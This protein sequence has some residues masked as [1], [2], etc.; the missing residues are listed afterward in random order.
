MFFVTWQST[1][2]QRS[3]AG[4]VSAISTISLLHRNRQ[5][6]EGGCH[7]SP[8]YDEYRRVCFKYVFAVMIKLG[9]IYFPVQR[10]S[11]PPGKG[12]IASSLSRGSQQ[13]CRRCLTLTGTRATLLN[14]I[15]DSG[16]GSC[17]K[18]QLIDI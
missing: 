7:Q 17:I 4:G 1:A 2:D 14:Y 6:L 10:K 8:K 12:K 9:V 18:I 5:R 3:L 16:R 11:Y 13:R 15:S